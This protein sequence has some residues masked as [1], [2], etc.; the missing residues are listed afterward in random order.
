MPAGADDR[1]VANSGCRWLSR[2]F[3]SRPGA[4]REGTRR[5]NERASS[6]QASPYRWLA[7]LFSESH[8]RRSSNFTSSTAAPAGISIRT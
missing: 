4:I 7:V 3:R 8:H 5:A 2:M 1:T 6:Y